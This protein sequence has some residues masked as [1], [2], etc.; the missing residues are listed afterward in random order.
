MRSGDSA[1]DQFRRATRYGIID[2][3]IKFP[4]CCEPGLMMPGGK[5][6][7][8]LKPDWVVGLLPRRANNS[9]NGDDD[10]NDDDEA[11]FYS[12]ISHR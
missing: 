12:A 1:H 8:A 11:L 3:K 9:N 4:F 7:D 6:T 2:T 10:D 5:K